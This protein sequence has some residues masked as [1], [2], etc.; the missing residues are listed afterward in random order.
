[1][2][3]PARHTVTAALPYA[4]GPLHIG[5]IAGAYLPA[6]IYVRSLRQRG[7]EV[8]FVCGS[9]EH[10]AA[11]TIRAMK[12]GTSPRAIVDKYHALMGKAFT[13]FGI[14]FDIYHRTSSELHKETS[15][16]FFLKLYDNGAFSEQEEQQYYDEEAKQFLADRYITGT[17]PKCGNADA[18]GDQCEKCG[19]A[20]SPKDLI[21]PRSTL[22]GSKPV[23][24]VTKHWYLKM[25]EA[26]QWVEQWINT[27]VLDDKQHHDPKE[28]KASVIGQCNSWLKDGLRPRAMTRDL[29]WGVPVPLPG[30][31]GKVLYVWLDAPIG[32]ISATKQWAQDKGV[33]WEK[34]WKGD[35][36]R[37]VHFI[38]KDNIVFH[39]IIFPILLK[40]HGGYVLPQNVPANE[41]L[42][43]EGRKISTSRNWA[44]WLH[45]YLERWPN[46]QDELRYCLATIIPEQKDSEF[47]W[48]DFQDK[49]NNELVAIIGNFVQR[50]FVLCHKYY[51][52][53]APEAGEATVDDLALWSTVHASIEDIARDVDQFRFREALQAAMNVAR[54]GNKY[55]S[56]NEPWKLEKT[57]P[58]RTRTILANS[59]NVTAVLALALEPFLPFTA[60]RLRKMLGLSELGWSEVFRK[61]LVGAGQILS[62]A[63]H[64]F[65]PIDDAAIAAEV[66]RLHAM[67][68]AQPAPPFTGQPKPENATTPKANI[69]FDDFAKLDLRVGTITAAERV[70]KADKLLKLTIEVGEAIP[71]TVV[72]GIA[73]YYAPEQLTGQ[74][75]VVVANLEPRKMRGVESQGMVLMAE[76]A[77]GKLVFVQPKDVIAPGSEVR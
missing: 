71:R 8:L 21:D 51:A 14:H 48:K 6:D 70:P 49:N 34:W 45:E 2:K 55:L 15:Q 35:D 74:Q 20:L 42:N 46:R 39:A 12:E 63:E 16:Q 40:L 60:D 30:A 19:S 50:V 65:K 68:P 1:M 69:A 33:A 76:D 29:D 7:K 24:K 67:E 66:D 22:S 43:L 38:G 58:E 27:G 72:S 47:T 4:N 3:E 26:Q 73:E 75:V 10:G 44:V 64:L 5:H 25:D 56:D 11:I 61:D 62:P 32:Y 54:A 36:S 9:D 59:L 28:W 23:L 18:Y 77:S 17:C 41:F 31:E 57:D 37:L 53:K 52:G 13:D